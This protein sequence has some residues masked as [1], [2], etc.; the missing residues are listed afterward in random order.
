MDKLS[1]SYELLKIETSFGDTNIILTGKKDNPPLVLLNGSSGSAPNAVEALIGLVKKFRVFTID[2]V[3][4]L[5]LEA[6]FQTNMKDDSYGQWMF[7]ILSRLNIWNVTLVGISFGGFI[8][9]KTLVFDQRRISRAFLVSP[10]GIAI[11]NS[12][13]LFWRILWPIKRY[14]WN[15]RAKHLQR[16][17]SQLFTKP[18][19]YSTSFLLK[20]LA[21]VEMDFRSIPLIS[22][23][24]AGKIEKPIYVISSTNDLLFPRKKLIKRASVIFPSL[25]EVL[26]LENSK[27]IPCKRGFNQIV[28]FINKHSNSF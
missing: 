18:D 16:L 11:E 22:E 7:E 12:L 9:L 15:G 8:S 1:I 10:A 28:E 19:D 5:N 17:S 21:H 25:V 6:E 2:I 3:D 14:Q 13:N 4:S 27:H 24:E 20:I 26:T 23:Q